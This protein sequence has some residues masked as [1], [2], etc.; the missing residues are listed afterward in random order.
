[1][2]IS[3]ETPYYS[4][5][6]CEKVETIA[7]YNQFINWI[8]GEFVLYQIEESDGLKVYFSNGWFTINILNKNKNCIKMAIKV[9]SKTLND[10]KKI[11]N[12]INTIF[13]NLNELE[14]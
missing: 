3:F 4:F 13:S 1:M 8:I 14:S 7:I 2:N 11:Q 12:K 9:K 6:K 10:G 5:K